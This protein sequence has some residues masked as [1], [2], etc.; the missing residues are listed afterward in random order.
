[1]SPPGAQVSMIGN[2]DSVELPRSSK[3]GG[4]K[5]KAIPEL[6]GIGRPSNKGM[7]KGG[8]SATKKAI[9][10]D[11]GKRFRPGMLALKEIKKMQQQTEAVIPKLPFQRLVKE[12]SRGVNPDIRYSSQGLIALQEAAESYLTGVFEDSYL[13]TLHAKRVTMMVKDM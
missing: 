9:R 7:G 3:V 11:G 10:K 2:P 6:G 4:G 12:I 13:C 8:L 1:M 5:A